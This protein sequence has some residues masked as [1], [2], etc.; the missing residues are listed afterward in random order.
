MTITAAIYTRMSM[1]RDGK[2][3]GVDV[4]RDEC[5]ALADK[6]GYTVVKC[7]SDNNISASTGKRRPDFEAMI[8][9]LQRGEF[10]VIICWHIDRLYRRPQELESLID[11]A[12]AGTMIVPCISGRIDLSTSDGRLQARIGV[13]VAKH[14]TEHKSER[15][16]IRNA[17]RRNKGQWQAFGTPPLGYA[18]VGEPG[19]YSL[20]KT[21]PYADLIKTA[22]E[23]V[24]KGVSLNAICRQW[25]AKELTRPRGKP[26]RP[27][28][29]RQMLMNPT[30]A[31][32]N[33]VA[34]TKED[35][36]NH[37]KGAILCPGNWPAIIPPDTHEALVRHLTDPSRQVYTF[38]RAHMGSGVYV[39][40]VCGRKLYT[41]VRKK[42]RTSGPS[43]RKYACVHGTRKHLSRNGEPIDK[44][45]EG[46]VIKVLS[47]SDIRRHLATDTSVDVAKLHTDRAVLKSKLQETLDNLDD[48]QMAGDIDAQEHHRRTK[49]LNE[50]HGPAIEKLTKQID[51]ASATSPALHLLGQADGDHDKLLEL[52]NVAPPA[53]RGAIIDELMTVTVLDSRRQGRV[54]DPSRIEIKP[55]NK[56]K[57]VF[58]RIWPTLSGHGELSAAVYAKAG[59]ESAKSKFTDDDIRAIKAAVA[60]G[61]PQASVGVECGVSQATISRVV[62]QAALS[63]HGEL[64]APVYVKKSTPYKKKAGAR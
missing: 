27:L 60:G 9:A 32:M 42:G 36:K 26:W 10:T 5:Q 22:A 11:F 44:I 19:N 2:A 47:D 62:R 37:R 14:E 18:R 33:T 38:N 57:P 41:A 40:G 20:V 7:Y 63:G 34:P 12:D 53:V 46:V 35:A 59:C 1:D 64:A 16:I 6:L 24:L 17:D 21:Q 15:Q 48:Q 3:V 39:C 50:K 58:K 25:T 28:D 4:Q 13:S 54:F 30:Y 52:W 45:V 56:M 43:T 31:A 8:A 49:R 55:T 23:D 61:Q 29:L 51:A